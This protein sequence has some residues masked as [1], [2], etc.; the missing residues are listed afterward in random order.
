MTKE[1]V[2]GLLSFV[3]DDGI[4]EYAGQVEATV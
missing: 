1:M 3:A 2:R 4:T